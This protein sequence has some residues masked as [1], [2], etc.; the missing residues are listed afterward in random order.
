[1]PLLSQIWILFSPAIAFF[2]Y[3]VTILGSVG[4]GLILLRCT[5]VI[6][7]TSFAGKSLF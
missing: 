4:T 6:K 7:R 1:V 5:W 3:Q 2:R